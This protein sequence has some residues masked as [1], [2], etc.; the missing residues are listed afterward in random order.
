MD[1]NDLQNRKNR[2][3]E[4][5]TNNMEGIKDGAE[6]FPNSREQCVDMIYKELQK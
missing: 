4:N 6:I 2:D 3:R 5:V 1:L